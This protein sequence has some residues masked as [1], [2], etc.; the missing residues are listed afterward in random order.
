MKWLI[1]VFLLLLMF[2]LFSEIY[3]IP[4]DY[5]T[6]QLGINYSSNC[7][8]L[9]VYPGI[10]YE[11]IDYLEKGLSINS[12]YTTTQDTSYISQT[13]IDGNN[14]GSVVTITDDDYYYSTLRGFTIRNGNEYHGGGICCIDSHLRLKNLIIIDNNAHQYGGGIYARNA[15]LSLDHVDLLNNTSSIWGGGA[16]FYYGGVSVDGCNFIGN[17]A[18]YQGGGIYCN[19]YNID[20]A[21]STITGNYAGCGAGGIYIGNTITFSETDRCNIYLNNVNSRY[22][23]SDL[24][25]SNLVTVYVDTFTVMDPTEYFIYPLNNFEMDILHSIETQIASDFYV[26]PEGDNANSG[27]T[28][29]DPLRSIQIACLR[30]L[31]TDDNPLSIYLAEGIYSPS[32]NGESFPVVLPRNVSLIGAGRELTILDAEYE[33]AVLNITEC[34]DVTI[35]GMT[36]INA[37]DENNLSVQCFWSNNTILSDL[38]ISNCDNENEGGV[39]TISGGSSSL[40]NIIVSG[41]NGGAG[42]GITVCGGAFVEIDSLICENNISAMGSA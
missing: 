25:A 14:E 26:S 31:A 33:S 42:G 19:T 36:I 35:S 27:L 40:H 34:S 22:F 17:S 28:P 37:H 24:S 13:I 4:E 11:N 20:M 23:G 6:I 29:E 9:I 41:N 38:R 3:Y 15:N 5:S 39:L 30:I 10:Y 7:D 8:T 1:F 21:G 32:S 2:T 16:Y 18:S 12:L